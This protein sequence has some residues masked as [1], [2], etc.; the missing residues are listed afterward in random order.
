MFN[1]TLSTEQA[2]DLLNDWNTPI[3]TWPYE[4]KRALLEILEASITGDDRPVDFDPHTWA[5]E[6][7]FYASDEAHI[8]ISDYEYLLL[9]VGHD[10][11]RVERLIDRAGEDPEDEEVQALIDD[12]KSI[13]NEMGVLCPIRRAAIDGSAHLLGWLIYA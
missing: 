11:A 4:A 6:W 5:I 13:V 10:P 9:D 2:I 8:L 3:K 1:L 12:L 7:T